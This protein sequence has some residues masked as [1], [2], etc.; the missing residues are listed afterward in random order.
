MRRVGHKIPAHLIEHNAIGNVAQQKQ[1]LVDSVGHDAT[2]QPIPIPH[3]GRNIDR[4]AGVTLSEQPRQ[5]RVTQDIVHTLAAV[6]FPFQ[7]GQRLCRSIAD[8]DFIGVVKNDRA[9]RHC[10]R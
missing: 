9:V 4:K 2:V 8:H 7:A 10:I 3:R 5:M 6:L 1:L